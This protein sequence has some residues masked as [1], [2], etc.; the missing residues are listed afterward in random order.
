MLK[1]LT[2]P[3]PVASRHQ[4][5]FGVV[6]LMVFFCL[7]RVIPH[8]PNFTALGAVLV[9]ASAFTG[10]RVWALLALWTGL[11]ITD[12]FLGFY[13]QMIWIYLTMAALMGLGYFL[14]PL[15]SPSRFL[16][17]SGMQ[18][19]L[20]FVVTNFA[21]W[22]T[23]AWYSKDLTGLIHCYTLAL[24][25]YGYQVLGDLV[26]IPILGGIIFLLKRTQGLRGAEGTSAAWGEENECR[27]LPQT[28]L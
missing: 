22:T 4:A 27:G 18:S 8:P 17:F 16:F 15:N 6:F 23:T 13:S 21:V 1:N 20:F 9:W 25:F 12:F 10:S 3:D 26:Y 28:R 11:L 24:P 7:S 2:H 14:K 19:F 5:F